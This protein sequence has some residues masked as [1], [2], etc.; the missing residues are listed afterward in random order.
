MT[1]TAP[2]SRWILAAAI[3]VGLL[4]L[5]RSLPVG[6][7]LRRLELWVAGLGGY[8]PPVLG[9]AY[10]LAALMMLPVWAMTIAAGALF[11]VRVGLITMSLASTAAAALAFLIARHLAR[12]P[13]LRLAQRHPRFQALDWA[14]GDAG[15]RIVALLRLVPVYPFSIGNYLFGVT[16]V[17][18]V[19][20]V[21]TSWATMLPSTFLYVYAGHA[22]VAS[23]AAARGTS[24][25]IGRLVLIGVGF[26]ALLAA[27]V[28]LTRSVRR[29]LGAATSAAAGTA[30]NPPA[31]P[32][33]GESA[34]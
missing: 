28:G 1:G 6:D 34:R 32:S 31:G 30:P 19:P 15:W 14:I 27:V 16:G 10:V 29:R 9:G 12:D 17:R 22:G 18:F 8:G 20:Y 33:S 13:V 26:L 7:C 21:I 24:L 2:L 5:A 3:V 11:G 4:L 23:L 25:D